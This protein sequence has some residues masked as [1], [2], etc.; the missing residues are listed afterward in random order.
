MS[1]EH[2]PARD[3]KGAPAVVE[4]EFLTEYEAASLLNVG[5]FALRRWRL[6]KTGPSWL[7]M[8]K[9]VRYQRRVLL[10][11][12]EAQSRGSTAA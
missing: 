6:E 4:S 7:K 2:S 9:Y 5:V 12:A 11:W 8:S 10:A 1:L 3:G